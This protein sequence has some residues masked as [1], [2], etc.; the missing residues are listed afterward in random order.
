[1]GKLSTPEWILEGYDS[2]AEWKK[3][4]G[5]GAAPSKKAATPKKEKK[6][7]K[8]EK[9]KTRT[10]KVRACP[11]CKSDIVKVVVGEEAKGLWIC[12]SCKWKGRN[13]EELEMSEDDFIQYLEDKEKKVK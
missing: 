9:G 12:E 11:K 1:M 3:A 2:P 8:S 5:L 7:S 4:K 13:V 6:S 10:F